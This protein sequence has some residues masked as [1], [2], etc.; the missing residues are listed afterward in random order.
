MP[1]PQ[2][3]ARR[4]PLGPIL[5]MANRLSPAPIL[6]SEEQTPDAPNGVAEVANQLLALAQM[7][8]RSVDAG[9]L[10]GFANLRT[11]R[12]HVS[13]ADLRREHGRPATADARNFR[14]QAGWSEW[15]LEYQQRG[16]ELACRSTRQG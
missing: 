4:S 11:R 2:R 10:E 3:V 14:P 12:M 9:E 13:A 8:R 7:R 1:F 6:I 15:G 5:D 16:V